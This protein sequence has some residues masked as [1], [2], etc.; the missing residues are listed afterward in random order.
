MPRRVPPP[1]FR[2]VWLLPGP[3]AGAVTLAG[4]VAGIGAV[5]L[6]VW[7]AGHQAS[8]I[9]PLAVGLTLGGAMVAAALL[10]RQGSRVA[11]PTGAREV[12]MAIVPW[13]IVVT[14]DTEPRVLRWPAI[15]HVD[16]EVAH[17]L[18]G[19]TPRAV[20]SIV[21]VRAGRD[22]LAG[23]TPG[24]AGLEDLTVNLAAYAEEA[25]RPLAGDLEGSDPIGDGVT[26]PVAAEL[27]R[28]A[29]ELCSSG[30]GAA[31]L[32]LPP[33]GYRDVAS[34]AA[35]PETVALLR[36]ALTEAPGA[37]DPR[38]LAAIVA[39]EL[40]AKS[41]VPALLRLGTAPHPLVA[42][43]AKAAALRLG[44]APNRAGSVDEVEAFL[45]P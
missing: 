37:A 14:P 29:R 3:T 13:G 24:S 34:R 12:P 31:R 10:A 41:L 38:A 6:A 40:G 44:V 43:A 39:A 32:S 36:A 22:V 2:Y 9:Q 45:L 19:G 15:E 26:E 42:A 23:R 5:A 18:Q 33:G 11:T 20:S 17:S 16:V 30:D 4:A 7:T 8:S 27:V 25:L 1:D 35:A 21:T 28:R